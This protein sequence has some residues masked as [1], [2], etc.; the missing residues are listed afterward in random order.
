MLV[1]PQVPTPK[2]AQPGSQWKDI[3]AAFQKGTQ[4]LQ[5]LVLYLQGYLGKVEMTVNNQIQQGLAADR[6]PAGNPNYLYFATDSLHLFIDN[7]T[8][9]VQIV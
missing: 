6:P 8:S 2:D 9:W 5:S 7:G 1:K 3:W 4:Y